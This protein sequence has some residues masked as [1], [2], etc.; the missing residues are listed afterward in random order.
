MNMM[1]ISPKLNKTKSIVAFL[2]KKKT[3]Q[4]KKK[5]KKQQQNQKRESRVPTALTEKDLLCEE[6]QDD[7]SIHLE[8]LEDSSNS[9]NTTSRFTRNED[10]DDVADDDDDEDTSDEQKSRKQHRRRP[11]RQQSFVGALQNKLH[12][13]FA[14]QTDLNAIAGK[15][16]RQRKFERQVSSP[17]MLSSS[18]TTPRPPIPKPMRIRKQSTTS[19]LPCGASY[20][21]SVFDGSARS[22][23]SNKSCSAVESPSKKKLT[24]SYA[25]FIFDADSDDE[26]QDCQETSHWAGCQNL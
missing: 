16:P 9:C 12:H 22:L 6:L 2:K 13:S 7:T 21:D 17:A 18:F 15:Q 1:N 19:T 25:E 20:C 14:R 11:Q 23:F 10:E 8:D 4:Q 26:R 24:T 3:K 5:K